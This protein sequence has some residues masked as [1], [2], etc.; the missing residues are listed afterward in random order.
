MGRFTVL[1]QRDNHYIMLA[2]HVD[3]NTILVEPFHSRHDRYCLAAYDR[4]MM[5]LNKCGH[6]IDLKILDNEFRETYKIII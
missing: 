5:R 3:T 1:S 6:T 2:F 4:I